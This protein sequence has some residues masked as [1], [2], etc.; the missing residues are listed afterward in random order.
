MHLLT[1]WEGRKGKYLAPGHGLRAQ[2]GPC[3]MA[4]SQIF[5]GPVRPNSVKKYFIIP[6]LL[7][8]ILLE[9]FVKMLLRAQ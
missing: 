2:R 7:C 8:L 5:S 9:K 3:V 1:D 4:E 6:P